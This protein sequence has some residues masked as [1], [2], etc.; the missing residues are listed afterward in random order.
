M[1]TLTN[2]LAQS[3]AAPWFVTS[4]WVMAVINNLVF[5]MERCSPLESGPFF[6][7]MVVC[8]FA[9]DQH[10]RYFGNNLYISRC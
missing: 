8:Y 2:L 10:G 5:G 7:Q 3:Q 9:C 6:Q 4:P 1:E